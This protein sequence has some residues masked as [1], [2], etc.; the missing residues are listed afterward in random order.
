MPATRGN[1]DGLS[2]VHAGKRAPDLLLSILPTH[3]HPLVVAGA[4]TVLMIRMALPANTM[5]SEQ[6]SAVFGPINKRLREYRHVVAPRDHG[7]SL[8]GRPARSYDLPSTCRRGSAIS[9]EI[10]SRNHVLVASA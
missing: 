2:Y 6:N 5:Y 1:S 7:R 3:P 9:P 4:T 10:L 8:P